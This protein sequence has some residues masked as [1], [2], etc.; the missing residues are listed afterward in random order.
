MLVLLIIILLT[1]WIA[2]CTTILNG[3]DIHK[4]FKLKSLFFWLSIVSIL[5]IT[6]K[7]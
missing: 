2:T 6:H 5:I 7:L 4:S 1:S 3:D